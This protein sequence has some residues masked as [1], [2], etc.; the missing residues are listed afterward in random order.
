M[1][2]LI[3][4]QIRRKQR[5]ALKVLQKTLR[6]NAGDVTATAKALAVGADALRKACKVWP[7]ALAALNLFKMGR[8]KSAEKA[9]E[10]RWGKQAVKKSLT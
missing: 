2:H 7:D 5:P 9:R 4:I 8:A 1:A 3:L 10:K 6:A